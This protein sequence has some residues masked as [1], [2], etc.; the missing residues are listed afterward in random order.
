MAMLLRSFL[1]AAIGL[2]SSVALAAGNPL[3]GDSGTSGLPFDVEAQQ[4][5]EYNQT[6]RQ[7][8]ARGKAKVTR[9]DMSVTGDTLTGFERDKKDGTGSEVYRFT[10]EGHV[11]V[12]NGRAVAYGDKADYNVD[13]QVAVMTGRDLKL[14]AADDILTARDRFEYYAAGQKAIAIGDA[15]AIRK[16]PQG[17]RTITADRMTAYFKKDAGGKTVADRIEAE[18]NVKMLSGTAEGTDVATGDHGSYDPD[19]SK[20]TLT[21]DV[22]LTRGPNQ[23]EG[24]TAEVDVNTGVSKLIG[25][26][27]GKTSDMRVRG[28]LIPGHNG[29]DKITGPAK[30]SSETQP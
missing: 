8:V 30:T 18:G 13:S 9:G 12:A 29:I 23:L 7:Y 24:N 20:A 28:L 11:Q 1:I 2:A 14:I 21:G 26:P 6:Q 22:K 10:A 15:K 4:S 17:T 3:A 16:T 27:D 25:T 19:S 5:L